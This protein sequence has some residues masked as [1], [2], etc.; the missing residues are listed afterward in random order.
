MWIFLH[1]NW[2]QLFNQ[3]TKIPEKN[4]DVNEKPEFRVLL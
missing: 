1:H 3:Q 4:M 2:E